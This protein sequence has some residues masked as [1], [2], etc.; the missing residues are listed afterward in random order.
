MANSNDTPKLQEYMYTFTTGGSGFKLSHIMEKLKEISKNFLR[1][2]TYA[3]I[4]GGICTVILSGL[5]LIPSCP[6][7]FEYALGCGAC[8]AMIAIIGYYFNI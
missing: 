2:I 1:A 5:S 7:N 4:F 6:W 8:T 3:F